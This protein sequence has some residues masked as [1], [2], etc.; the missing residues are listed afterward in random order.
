[1]RKTAY[2][3]LLIFCAGVLWAAGAKADADR[4]LII[5]D[6]IGMLKKEVRRHPL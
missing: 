2:P 6:D 1:M 5:D 4:L 3:V